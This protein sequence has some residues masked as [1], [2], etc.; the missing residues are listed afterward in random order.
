MVREHSKR[1]THVR[2][3]T[4]LLIMG[5][6]VAVMAAVLTNSERVVSAQ[7][8]NSSTT[9]MAPEAKPTPARRSRRGRRKPAAPAADAA[10]APDMAATPAAT[11]EK[12]TTGRC[13]PTQQEQ[14]DLSGT[15][16]GKLKHGNEPAT[17]ATL[18]ITGNSFSATMGG[19][20][21]TGRV[22]AVTTCG[23]TAVTMMT[24]DATAPDPTKPPP[25][26]LPSMSLRAKKV[27]DSLTLTTIPGE[28]E[29][30]SF[31]SGSPMKAAPRK[32]RVSRKPK[33]EEPAPTPPAKQ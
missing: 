32:R 13:D 11:P 1:R 23:Y 27:G 12:K 9:M 18:T 16:T 10:A 4:Y 5:L 19:E 14:T 33:T 22:T 31:T 15:Y 25:P 6:A 7:N 28:K 30:V 26:P 3:T 24:G 17:D 29:M 8:A 21:R 2:K 20:T